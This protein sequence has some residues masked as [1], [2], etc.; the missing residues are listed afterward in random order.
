MGTRV[1]GMNKV[2]TPGLESPSHTPG[3]SQVPVT[4]RSN[5]R[6]RKPGCPRPNKERGVGW[7]DDERFVTCVSLGSREQPDL[8]LP[9]SPRFPHIDVQD[10]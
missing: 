10:P 9:P 3:R 5:R 2:G 7:R 8:S 6:Y 4:G 1:V